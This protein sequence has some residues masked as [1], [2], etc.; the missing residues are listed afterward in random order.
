MFCPNCGA[1]NEV[2][3]KFCHKCGTQLTG[4]MPSQPSAQPPASPRTMGRGCFIGLILGVVILVLLPIIGI[5]AA[6]AIPN[7]IEAQTRAKVSRARADLRAMAT[8]LEMYYVDTNDYPAWSDDPRQNAFGPEA[9]AVRNLRQVPTFRMRHD[10]DLMTLTT[11]V[12]YITDYF[13]DP[14]SPDSMHTF[15]FYSVNPPESNPSA[16]SGWVM[17]GRGPDRTFDLNLNLV[18]S[19]YDPAAPDPF[20]A[21]VEFSFDP[22]NGTVSRGDIIRIQE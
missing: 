13:D 4:G 18:S 6:I 17:W 2:F 21:L 8:A 5:L 15:A 3:A 1:K 9:G 10:A 7:F 20:E 12:T 19:L 16:P 14:F 11:P 22:T